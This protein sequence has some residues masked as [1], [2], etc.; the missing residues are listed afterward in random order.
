MLYNMVDTSDDAL[1]A[2]GLTALGSRLKR[3][4]E[5]LQAESQV[6]LAR[7]EP[8]IASGQHP[9]LHTIDR[10]A[11]LTIG[12]L[13]ERLGVTQPGVTR[14]LGQLAEAGLVEVVTSPDDARRRL[15]SLTAD[16]TRFVAEAKRD[17]WPAVEAAVAE[18]CSGFAEELLANLRKMEA[19]L[20]ARPLGARVKERDDEA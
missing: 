13:A 16:G 15:V 5:R 6:I 10:F 2:L 20:E 4:G 12:E 9:M 17:A 18:L 3:L 14:S 7:V 8:A 11:P 19:G 1:R